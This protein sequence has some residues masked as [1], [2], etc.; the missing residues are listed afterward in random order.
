MASSRLLSTEPYS[1]FSVLFSKAMIILV[2]LVL[3]IT[4]LGHGMPSTVVEAGT[5]VV[6]ILS[7]SAN[8]SQVVTALQLSRLIPYVNSLRNC[9]LF[10]PTDQAFAMRSDLR[11]LMVH[12]QKGREEARQ[13][14]RDKLLYHL[15][16]G[17]RWDRRH[18]LNQP[19]PLPPTNDTLLA[20][21]ADPD[22]EQKI[23]V[24]G[25]AYLNGTWMGGAGVAMKI[26]I[27]AT[28]PARS[29]GNGSDDSNGDETLPEMQ[30]KVANSAMVLRPDLL[31]TRGVVHEM[32]DFL[33]PPP[34][35]G[36]LLSH[37]ADTDQ[38]QQALA[39]IALEQKLNGPGPWTI[40]IPEDKPF[41]EMHWVERRYLAHQR[42]NDDLSQL[43][44]YHVHRGQVYANELLNN[45]SAQNVKTLQGESIKVSRKDDQVSVNGVP[46]E[47]SD[48]I[49]SNG[50]IHTIKSILQPKAFFLNS[51]KY[52][53]G[54]D[55]TQFVDD[56]STTRMDPITN[57]TS[58]PY[59]FIAVADP[60]LTGT[61]MN[62]LRGE[63]L[64]RQLQYQIIPGSLIHNNQSNYQLARS[65]LTDAETQGVHQPVRVQLDSQGQATHIN[66][67][68]VAIGP[69]TIGK[70]TIYMLR[71]PFS[72]PTRVADFLNSSNDSSTFLSALSTTKQLA[73][74]QNGKAMTLFV[75]TEAAFNTLGL[76]YDAMQ[77]PGAEHKLL[78]VIK[79]T[80]AV[81][82]V[83][84]SDMI[85]DKP[86]E[87]PTLGNGTITLERVKDPSDSA[88]EQI[89][90][91]G[92]SS[93]GATNATI[94]A[95]DLPIRNGVVHRIDN[96]VVPSG[97]EFTLREL[98]QAAGGNTFL[99][100]IDRLGLGSLI[101]AHKPDLSGGYTFFVPSDEAF[102]QFNDTLL[103][104][105]E[106]RMRRIIL[107]HIVATRINIGHEGSAGLEFATLL[108]DRS[109]HLEFE[110]GNGRLKV[111]I[112]LHGKDKNQLGEDRLATIERSG[113]IPI[114]VVHRIDTVLLDGRI[115]G[116]SWWIVLL[117][118]MG[119]GGA[120][121]GGGFYGYQT[122]MKRRR[123]AAGYES[124]A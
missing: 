124:L 91:R 110:R 68:E 121:G 97:V 30:I 22:T 9:T 102:V 71:S 2:E 50:V 1:S 70:H 49:G 81:D 69:I 20:K 21:E 99:K 67:V 95:P 45:A 98:F 114:G 44:G 100:A 18:L 107:G 72:A 65:I 60:Q 3:L 108:K 39:Q 79:S 32:D 92:Q 47:S 84:Y 36:T 37:M 106:M 86:Y 94:V 76:V 31:A 59:T 25:S 120:M 8:F 87:I 62:S 35:I 53:I 19:M 89:R 109:I 113:K 16:P 46:L 14:L 29:M 54:L 103:F 117:G 64:V 34:D 5:T 90:I 73:D 48:W 80:I 82:G 43:L 4:L 55:A 51:Y 78:N 77:L 7:Q 112:R 119:V 61:A 88:K 23:R 41:R 123:E 26:E 40:F 105:D 15:V 10:A 93:I 24:L 104:K 83:L 66:D 6:D 74:V 118:T 11:L 111:G 96:I 63:E 28:P 101:D 17:D 116:W 12:S 75:P 52:L 27:T 38:A 58:K 85:T 13:A 57:D 122:W 42:G 115:P 56:L 33:T